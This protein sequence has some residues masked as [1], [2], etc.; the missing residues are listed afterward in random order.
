[1]MRREVGGRPRLGLG[2]VLLWAGVVAASALAGEAASPVVILDPQVRRLAPGERRT[3]AVRV[4]GIPEGGLAAFQI[5]LRFEPENVEVRDPNAGYTSV[6]VPAFAPLGGS[7]L[8]ATIRLASRCPDPDWLLTSTGRQAMGTTSIDLRQ[9]I[10]TI[11]Y[12]TSGETD[13]ATGSGTLA[14]LEVVGTGRGKASFTIVDAILAD[15]T[16][17]PRRYDWRTESQQKPAPARIR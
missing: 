3:I 9:G 10:V 7:P 2:L 4:E 6:G 15:G 11:A 12:G 16:D 5:A 13:P 14:L 1:M 8:C 17:P